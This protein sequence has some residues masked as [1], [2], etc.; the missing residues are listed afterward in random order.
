M[1]PKGEL[2]Q[3]EIVLVDFP[4]VDLTSRKLRPALVASNKELNRISNAI[5]VLQITSNLNS[6]FAEYNVGITDRDVIRYAGTRPLRP[7]LIKPYVVFTLEKSLIRKRIGVLREE[8]IQEVKEG[9]KRVF[10]LYGQPMRVSSPL[11]RN[12]PHHPERSG[13]EGLK[14]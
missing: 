10:G 6:G 2:S 8:K 7:S 5:V 4:F 14:S 3:W 9:L 11:G 1:N 12:F 13:E